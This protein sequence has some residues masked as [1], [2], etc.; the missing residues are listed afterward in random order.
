MC[1]V[2]TDTWS[3]R[4]KG[5]DGAAAQGDQQAEVPGQPVLLPH[6]CPA[7]GE[8]VEDKGTWP[9]E[10]GW[11]GLGFTEHPALLSACG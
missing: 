2:G 5:W 1:S 11:E 9:Q 3:S 6:H 10:W 7:P 4:K 8:L